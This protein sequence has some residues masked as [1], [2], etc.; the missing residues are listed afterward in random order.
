MKQTTLVSILLIV[1]TVF[2]WISV[3]GSMN[4]D[5]TYSMYQ[6]YMDKAQICVDRGLYERAVLEYNSAIDLMPNKE[7]YDKKMCVWEKIYEEDNNTY[8][9]Y[10]NELKA[11][12]NLFPEDTSYLLKLT[13]VYKSQSMF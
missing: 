13:E 5:N 11:V 3:I 8:Y 6:E 10:I 9:D 1:L 12:V 4:N 7:A 2:S